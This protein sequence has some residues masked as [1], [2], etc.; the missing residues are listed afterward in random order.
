MRVAPLQ[1]RRPPRGRGLLF[2]HT[3]RPASDA[4]SSRRDAAMEESKVEVL[5][6]VG[7][8]VQSPWLG[9]SVLYFT[10]P[11][12]GEVWAM[13]LGAGDPPRCFAQTGGSP[14][15]VAVSSDGSVFVAD[16]A[17]QAVLQVEEGG[18][19]VRPAAPHRCSAPQPAARAPSAAA[20][21]ILRLDRRI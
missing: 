4:D 14:A 7:Q 11:E 20:A 2:R 5:A 6:E 19:E 10:A 12:A 15:A 3:P 9:G 18:R 16:E 17:F 1:A 8:S 21:G 13:D